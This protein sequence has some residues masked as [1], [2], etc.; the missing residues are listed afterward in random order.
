MNPQPEVVEQVKDLIEGD[1]EYYEEDEYDFEN[2]AEDEE[3]IEEEV[4]E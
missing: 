4:K 2:G 1:Q 3:A